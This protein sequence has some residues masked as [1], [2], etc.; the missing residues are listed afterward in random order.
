MLIKLFRE[1]VYERMTR[2]DFTQKRLMWI[3]SAFGLLCSFIV[4]MIGLRPFSGVCA[5]GLSLHVVFQKALCRIQSV[6]RVVDGGNLDVY[7]HS[8]DSRII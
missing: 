2:N 6:D 8:L 4:E 5:D 1:L 7:P 3:D